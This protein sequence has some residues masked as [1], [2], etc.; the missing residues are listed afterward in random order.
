MREAVMETLQTRFLPEFLNRIDEIMIFHPLE[1]DQIRKIVDLQIERLRKQLE[2]KGIDAGSDRRGPRRD[3]RRGLRPDL[4]RPAAEAGDPAADPKPAGGRDAQ[5]GVRRRQPR[6]DRLR[7]RGV[8]VRA[9]MR[10]RQSQESLTDE[11]QPV[12]L[13]R[14][15]SNWIDEI[16][17]ETCEDHHGQNH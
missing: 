2:E 9:G 13:N 14:K 8:Y 1:P 6:E 11:S 17:E 10:N 15:S 5:A 3:R 12:R 4:R 16:A 7:G